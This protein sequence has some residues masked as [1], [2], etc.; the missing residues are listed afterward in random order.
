[1]L[2]GFMTWR[3]MYGGMTL[4]SRTWHPCTAICPACR[5]GGR[6]AASLVNGDDPNVLEIWNNVFIQFNREAD[7]SLR[8]LPA[9]HVDTGMGLERITSILQVRYPAGFSVGAPCNIGRIMISEFSLPPHS[10]ISH[11]PHIGPHICLLIPALMLSTHR[12]RCPT[13]RPTSS[14]PSL[15]RSGASR[16]PG[17]TPTRYGAVNADRYTM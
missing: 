14:C 12:A 3:S 9:K 8:S 7:G 4:A 5:I 15:M 1:M 16:V 17:P 13:M 11:I 2:A 10:G 6:D